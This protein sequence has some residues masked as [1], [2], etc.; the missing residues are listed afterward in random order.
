LARFGTA[1]R[2]RRDRVTG[3]T[4]RSSITPGKVNP[5]L[6][7]WSSKAATIVGCDATSTLCCDTGNFELNVTMPVVTLKLLEAIEFTANA[8]SEMRHR[9]GGERTSV[10]NLVEKS[11]AMV[12][13]LFP[14][15]VMMPPR[16]LPMKRYNR[17]TVREWR[18]SRLRLL[19]SNSKKLW[20]RGA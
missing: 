19:R 5:V 16:P 14:V 7:E 2:D 1:L 9:H 11:L 20:P 17:N 13:A 3:H 8:L 12:T 6:C 4:A 18:G 10:R 15:I